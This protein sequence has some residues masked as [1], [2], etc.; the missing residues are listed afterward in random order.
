MLRNPLA[1]LVGLCA[2]VC[3]ASADPIQDALDITKTKNPVAAIFESNHRCQLIAPPTPQFLTRMRQGIAVKSAGAATPGNITIP[4]ILKDGKTV[5]LSEN[6][7]MC[8]IPTLTDD[9]PYEVT[10]LNTSIT[11]SI[12]YKNNVTASV[13]LTLGSWLKV[14][15]FDASNI[16]EVGI[17]ITTSESPAFNQNLNASALAIKKQNLCST[18]NKPNP[19]IIG[20]SCVG[21]ITI[22]LKANKDLSL[23][24]FD[25]QFAKL[26][27][28]LKAAWIRDVNGASS[29]CTVD[30]S[31]VSTGAAPASPA[32]AEE[33]KGVGVKIPLPGG[34]EVEINQ[35]TIDALYKKPITATVTSPTPAQVAS[36]PKPAAQPAGG[37][38]AKATQPQAQN[39]VCAKNVIYQTTGLQTIGVHLLKAKE[40]IDFAK[41]QQ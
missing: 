33:K 28:G 34:G 31:G 15:D 8:P 30:A 6:G 36:V 1:A 20:R 25:L 38:P 3:S 5:D 4:T 16:E 13:K 2:T 35:G 9:F 21:K 18:I 26:T 22:S 41:S 24:A 7:S 14:V 19:Y 39:K 40:F 29:D 17:W 10:D 37:D 11:S 32:S 27:V 23:N 12:A